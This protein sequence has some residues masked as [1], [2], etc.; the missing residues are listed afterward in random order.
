MKKIISLLLLF[1]CALGMASCSL[2]SAY[3]SSELISVLE[4]KG[5][6]I[7]DVD[8]TLQEG[9][10]GHIY[11]SKA[12]TGDELYYVY[13]SDVDTATSLYE[14]VKAAH[15]V[16]M[17]ELNLEIEKIEYALNKAEGLSVAEK[18]DYYEKYVVKTEELELVSSYTYGRAVNIVWYGTK[19]AIKD[20]RK[21]QG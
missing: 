20:I 19:D 9:I 17:A 8:Q 7:T 11:A 15:K 21:N 18:G 16:R 2:V 4:N 12:D 13:C 14:Y 3:D 10:V 1:A 5:Y 6:E